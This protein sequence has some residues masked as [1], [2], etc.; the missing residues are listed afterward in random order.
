MDAHSFLWMFWIIKDTNISGKSSEEEVQDDE[1]CVFCGG[2]EG[3]Q[4]LF[5]LKKYE[6]DAKLRKQAIQIHGYRCAAC[7]KTM[8]EMYGSLGANYI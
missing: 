2:R 1:T 8:E 4:R 5:Y 6:R 7:D 3:A